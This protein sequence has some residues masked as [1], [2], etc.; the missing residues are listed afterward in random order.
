[1]NDKSTCHPDM[2]ENGQQWARLVRCQFS[3]TLS[4]DE[5]EVRQALIT[6]PNE[7]WK[8]L[9]TLRTVALDATSLSLSASHA[10]CAAEYDDPLTYL[11]KLKETRALAQNIQHLLTMLP[12]TEDFPEN[13]L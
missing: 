1:M 8:I 10:S 4:Q 2:P 3:R 11:R 9:H 13:E 12:P 5:Q 7:R 6:T